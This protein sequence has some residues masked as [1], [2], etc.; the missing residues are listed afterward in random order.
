MADKKRTKSRG[1]PEPQ[2]VSNSPSPIEVQNRRGDDGVASG[3]RRT[4]NSET[5]TK[6]SVTRKKIDAWL[7]NLGWNTDE[8]SPECNVTTERAKTGRQN[9]RLKGNEPDYV[10]YRSGTTQVLGII[11][12]KRKGKDLE[13]MLQESI[14]KYAEPLNAPLMFLTDGTFVISWH[15]AMKKE[16]T[17]DEEPVTELLPERLL[18]RFLEEGTDITRESK[19]IAQSREQLMEVFRWANDI[20]RKEGIREGFDRFIE[21]ANLLFLKLI[22]EME[23][24]REKHGEQRILKTKYCWESF[25]DLPAESMFEYVNEVVLRYLVERYNRTGDV[26]QTRLEIKTP[27]TLK[28]IVKRL[29]GLSL[30]DAESDVKGDA[31]EY[32][33][34]NSVT[35]GNDL[36]EYFTP[37]HIV[38]LMVDLADP[39]FGERVYDP[40]C[41]TGG[42]L[43]QAFNHIRRTCK[44]T[45]KT[46]RILKEETVFGR[47]L[48]N[49]S[50]I[51]KMNMIITGD[52]HTNI[53]QIDSLK[54]PVKEEYDIVL[55]NPPYGQTT[56][57]GDLY[58]VSTTRAD[59]IFIQHIMKSLNDKGRAAVIVPE[60]FLFRPG[61]D[62]KVRRALLKDFDLIAIISLPQGV[63]NPYTDSK[64]NIMIFQKDGKP[65]KDVW[66]YDIKHDGF[67]LGKTRKK[68]DED[69]IPDLKI[70]WENK[71]ISDSSWI[72]SIDEIKASGYDIRVNAH[73][74]ILSK[75]SEFP[76]AKFSG[77]LKSR[78][79]RI[80]M[81]DTSEYKRITVKLYGE[82]AILRDVIKG[83]DV[84]TKT[85]FVAREGNLIVSKIDARN[86]AFAIVPKELDGAIVSN[87]F[88]LFDV[89][90]DRIDLEYLRYFVRI[91][92][93]TGELAGKSRGT[94][95]RMRVSIRT[96]LDLTIPLPPLEKQREIVERLN[97]QN[98][99]ILNISSTL[100][101]I[102]EVGIEESVFLW[103][104]PRK[105]LNEI[106]DINMGQSPPGNTYNVE[107]KGMPF[108]QGPADLNTDTTRY[109]TK[110]NKTA[111]E[112]D[113]L[114]AVRA[115]VGDVW[116]LDS[117]W[118]IGR[119]FAILKPKNKT[120]PKF[121]YYF[122]KTQKE[123]IEKEGR[124]STFK[125]I[126]KTH[127]M[128][129]RVPL[130][131]LKIQKQVV[132]RLDSQQDALDALET[133]KNEAENEMKDI[134]NS[135]YQHVKSTKKSDI[136]P[137]LNDFK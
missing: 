90:E 122:L 101:S 15:V 25:A 46:L 121:L 45:P 24:D 44:D 56:D 2:K 107:A 74:E 84:Q 134:I 94:T 69:D 64:T 36:G 80:K 130:P 48:T 13:A 104:W 91:S 95:N 6:E 82:G 105:K 89:K 112:N 14:E 117:S 73:R 55:A 1:L 71:E 67:D 47:E 59:C 12:A 30:I 39:R 18:L 103:N 70:K 100:T 32:F 79:E 127:L 11:E 50:R 77:F 131:S 115:T 38:R 3:K 111:K 49:T 120:N 68:I 31:F 133:L 53:K 116:I 27:K 20:L 93:F 85:W 83:K 21:F 58:P 118:C 109:T 16:L 66:F 22:S 87:D 17:I 75:E 99:I 119:G 78:T 34:K 9:K 98:N 26:F 88:P 23:L 128:N 81:D 65:T 126:T 61:P 8:E 137:R 96:M 123:D 97:K 124:G 4:P 113:V 7:I 63:F 102:Q 10:L 57:W 40:T 86:G 132:D 19:V 51:A 28:E 60:G 33:L 62:R 43:I 114:I 125:A 136:T 135:L 5:K 41:G 129:I 108:L 37:R 52:G 110:P 106:A 92:G 42:F 35:V 72:A 54:S 29:S 76:V